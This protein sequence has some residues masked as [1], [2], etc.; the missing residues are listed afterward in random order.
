LKKLQFILLCFPIIGFGQPALKTYV[1]D[2]NFENY[3]EANGM[4]DGIQLNDSIN[5]WAIEML[6]T[7]DISNQNISDLTG[8]EDF[9][10]LSSLDCSNNN[11]TTLDLSQNNY[12]QILDC[13]Y[14]QITSLTIIFDS[15][16]PFQNYSSLYCNNNQLT[17]LDLSQSSCLTFVSGESSF[18]S[19][20]SLSCIQVNNY[21]CWQNNLINFIDTTYQYYNIDCSGTT[22]FRDVSIQKDIFKVI[23]L[24]GRETKGKKNQPLF[25]L[26]DDGTVEK[27]LMIE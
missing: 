6:I 3:L 7:L 26:H 15:L 17:S 22:D 2:D 20:T 14:N 9:T 19:N 23:D 4:G 1:P 24:L 12:L 18:K 27:R 8:I 21:D 16:H 10:V 5:F 11:L 25:Y 13:S